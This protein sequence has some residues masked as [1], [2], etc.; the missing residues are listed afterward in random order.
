MAEHLELWPVFE[1]VIAPLLGEEDDPTLWPLLI[2]TIYADA[3]TLA[4]LVAGPHRVLTQIGRCAHWMAPHKARWTADG[5]FAWPSGYGASGFSFTGLPEFD[6]SAQWAW[7]PGSQ[8]WIVA[9]G[10]PSSQD[11]VFRVAVPARTRRH[12]QAAVHTVWRPG[13]PPL[14]RVEVMQF[15]GFRR[16]MAEWSCT[17]YRYWS[18][19][20]QRVYEKTIEA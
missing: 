17:A 9:D 20:G 6:W 13:A 12:R 15:Y 11:L 2:D 1:P 3:E 4:R 5:S 19:T 16:V 18:P 8:S 14:P 7:C 10:R